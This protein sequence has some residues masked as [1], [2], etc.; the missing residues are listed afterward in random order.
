[1][2]WIVKCAGLVLVVLA[3]RAGL[4]ENWQNKVEPRLLQGAPAT[5]EFILVFSEQADLSGAAAFK[6]KEAKGR[7]VYERLSETAQ[8]TQAPVLDEL[9]RR[10]LKHRSFWIANAIWAQGDVASIQALAQRTET[11]RLIANFHARAPEV[12]SR[13]VASKLTTTLE[14]NIAQ[15]HAPDVWALGYTGQG[16][17]VGGQ[18]T[19][20]Q[21]NHPALIHHYR[22]WDGTNANHNYNW[23]DAI[24]TTD[25]HFTSTNPYGYNTTSPCDDNGHG[26]HTMGTMAGDDGAGNQIGVAPG[27][28]WIGCRNMERGWGTPAAYAECF[29]WFLAPTDLAG[30][31]PDPAKA[32]DVIN[33]SWYSDASE[34]TTNLL[35]FQTA[36]E[37]LRAAGVVVVVS[38]GNQGPACS[39]ITSP[40]IYDASFSVGATDSSDIIAGFSS[41]GPVAVDGSG[42][43]KPNV[44]APGVNIRSSVPV[45]GYASGWSGT[46]MA[47]PH[48][49]GVVALLIS[50]HPELK[51]QVDGIER[52]IEHTAVP[53]TNSESCGGVAGTEIPNNTYGWGRVDALAALG[54][55]DADGDGLP[56]WWE[57]WHNLNPNDSSDAAL[58][59]D[60]DGV[61]NLYEYLAGTDPRDETD[62]F[63]IAS[64]ASGSICVLSFQS[65]LNRLY[66]LEVR[67]NLGSGSWTSVSGQVDIAGNAGLLELSQANSPS[68]MTQFYRIKVRIAP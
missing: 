7:Y 30:Q 40:A 5:N 49:V 61:I 6:T 14:W 45:N 65:A 27:A 1:M 60:N 29:Q 35:V 15:I 19:G 28:R 4:P 17:V 63:H 33:D 18:D 42:R 51:G 32:P 62:F 68:D 2:K 57:L 25:S 3:G 38:A 52:I 10:G 53:L 11:V 36:V 46:S 66:T 23:H 67:T 50:A 59:S 39:T 37:N 55:N 47:G 41:R 48:V 22:G 24:H 56:D 13:S 26:T 20:Y 54:L 43:L 9:Q 34:G 16:V 31:N 44:T 8:R 21:W 58:D 64:I 12:P